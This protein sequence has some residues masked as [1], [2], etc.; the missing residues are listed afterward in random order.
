M[1]YRILREFL[2]RFGPLQPGGDALQ[3]PLSNWNTLAMVRVEL[4]FSV[5]LVG[6]AVAEVADAGA[7]AVNRPVTAALKR[8]DFTWH[9]FTEFSYGF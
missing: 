5:V 7:A 8:R 1:T 3:L 6:A 2:Q 9:F 4:L